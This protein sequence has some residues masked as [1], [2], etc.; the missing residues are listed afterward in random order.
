VLV[1]VPGPD[2]NTAY[3]IHLESSTP[4]GYVRLEQIAYNQG[5]GWY[6]QKTFVLP[7]LALR[8]LLPHLKLADCLIPRGEAPRSPLRIVPAE[9]AKRVQAG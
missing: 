9:C 3:R 6:V 7:G 1:T 8:A 2:E 5:L 4:D